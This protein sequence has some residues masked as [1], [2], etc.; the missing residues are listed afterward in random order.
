MVEFSTVL[1]TVFMV[2]DCCKCCQ[3]TPS[4][5][6]FVHNTISLL[7]WLVEVS[8]SRVSDKVPGNSTVI[9]GDIWS[10]LKHTTSQV[11]WSLH[12]KNQPDLWSS[13]DRTL[14]YDTDRHR[15]IIS[16][17]L[18]QHRAL[19]TIVN[20]GHL[21]HILPKPATQVH[22]KNKSKTAKLCSISSASDLGYCIC[23]QK[24]DQ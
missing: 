16:T 10:S 5:M 17:T 4:L 19:K 11:E 3:Q 23:Q 18:A 24:T 21:Y 6:S 12:A 7:W 1:F 8:K 22:L 13:F 20:F 2:Q 15:A 14:T 9:F